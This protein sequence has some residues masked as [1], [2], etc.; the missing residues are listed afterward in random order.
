MLH[1]ICLAKLLKALVR[2]L[3]TRVLVRVKLPGQHIVCPLHLLWRGI[4]QSAEYEQEVKQPCQT[5]EA[6]R[7]PVS[8]R[9]ACKSAGEVDRQQRPLRVR[10]LLDE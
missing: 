4:L 9:K 7:I 3:I 1:L 10:V 6:Q 5:A 2:L 8:G